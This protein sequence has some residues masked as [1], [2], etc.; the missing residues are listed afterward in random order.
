[1]WLLVLGMKLYVSGTSSLHSKAKLTTLLEARVL[2]S[3]QAWISDEDY[4][5]LIR[6]ANED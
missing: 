5:T 4:K 3:P 6:N 2:Y 1:M